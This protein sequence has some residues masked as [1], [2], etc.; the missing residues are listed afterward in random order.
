[1]YTTGHRRT[2]QLPVMALDFGV[3]GPCGPPSV[4]RRRP[5]IRA[6]GRVEPIHFWRR[7]PRIGR[8]PDNEI[9]LDDPNVSRHHAVII[10]TGSSYVITDLHSANGV[11]VRN[12]R[13]R[14]T[15]RLGHGDRIR[16]CDHEF[17]FE[18]G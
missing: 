13:I 8:L 7:R 16:I 11:D 15:A 6:T 9:V 14:D 12:Q 1:M 4:L 5:P 2:A 17:T 3:L 10:D 18:I